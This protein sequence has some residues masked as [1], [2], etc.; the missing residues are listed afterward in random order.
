MHKAEV[1]W[2]TLIAFLANTAETG[3]A[4]ANSDEPNATQREAI[5][6]NI[7]AE[8]KKRRAQRPA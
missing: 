2:P 5:N 4:V 6:E 3:K 8:S 1:Y 7:A